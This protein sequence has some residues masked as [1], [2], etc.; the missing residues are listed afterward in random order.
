MAVASPE[1]HSP[2]ARSP[3]RTL[4]AALLGVLVLLIALVVLVFV[5]SGVT[6]A[7]DASA[8]ARV[9]V[10]PL[11]GT[12]E[13]LEA[14]GPHGGHIPIAV[15][16]GR[17]TPQRRLPPGT[18]LTV[19]VTVKRP[20]W[21]GWALGEEATVRLTL[22]TPVAAV[23]QQWMTVRGGSEVRLAFQEPIREVVYRGPHGVHRRTLPAGSRSVSL[24]TQPP[25]GTVQVAAAPRSWETVGKST[26]VSWFPPSHYPVMATYPAPSSRITPAGVIY[27]TFSK[28]VSDVLGSRHPSLAPYTPGRWSEPD[29]HTLVFRPAGFG[30]LSPLIHDAPGQNAIAPPTTADASVTP[31]GYDTR[32]P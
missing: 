11:G 13:H 17:L 8:L 19:L 31:A 6:L 7:R 12:I 24:G 4:M 2:P 29:S 21:I 32:D 18:P 9:D 5:L 3:R 25:T 23:N 10:K 30:A 16:D 22:T 15:K 28:P 14:L 1:R 26:P 20:G 27:L